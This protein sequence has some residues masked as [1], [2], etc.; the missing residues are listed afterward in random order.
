M[1]NRSL[2]ENEAYEAVNHF[3]T[4]GGLP[5]RNG[6][7]AS[8]LAYK[9][10]DMKDSIIQSREYMYFWQLMEEYL[11]IPIEEQSE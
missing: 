9:L 5:I 4:A 10:R 6:D 7:K 3:L 2:Y 11:A 8:D 1:G